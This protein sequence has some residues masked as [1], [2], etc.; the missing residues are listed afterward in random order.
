MA[1]RP[2]GKLSSR[3][4]H[5]IWLADVSGSMNQD[6]K[7]QALNNAIR[8]VIPHMREV[9][10]ENPNAE[11]LV[12]TITFSTGA[13][14]YSPE[15]IPLE[16]FEWQD[17]RADGVTDMGK[18]LSL[19]AQAMKVP[20][21]ENRA[22]PPV[23]VLITDGLPSDDF[24][25][26]LKDLMAEP[27]GQKAVRLAIGIGTDADMDVLQK[28]IGTHKIKPLSANNPEALVQSIKWASTVV[29]KQVTTPQTVAKETAAIEPMQNISGEVAKQTQTASSD[30]PTIIEPDYFAPN[31][32]TDS[33]CG[34]TW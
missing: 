24:E 28:F 29:L 7:I 12:R 27:W 10:N 2:G 18:A 34:D 8:E 6:G 32:S 4:L 9:A 31:L 3:P 14:W 20:P 11:V 1:K 30:G 19:L 21:M 16:K 26:G 13:K 33:S 22:L 23:L 17:L 15:P 5:F 25:T